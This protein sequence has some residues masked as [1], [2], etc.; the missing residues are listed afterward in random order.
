MSDLV[1]P[2]GGFLFMKVGMHAQEELSDIIARKQAEI[3]AAGFAMWG[4]GGNTCHP[5]TMVQPFAD[6]CVSAGD[7]ILLCMQPMVSNHVAEPIRA[8][9]YS[10]DGKS[11]Q[12]IPQEIAVLGSKYA[13]CIREL[14]QVDA[15]ISLAS[16]RVALGRSKGR[17]GDQYVKG[18]VDKAC[19]TMVGDDGHAGASPTRI[20]L[21]A[22]IVE[23]YAVFLRY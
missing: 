22:Q 14:E 23:P 10:V 16:T 17:A 5:R 15:E 18:R 7:P 13:L 20:G 6:S 9:E 12:E 21:V 1:A 19:L 4:Y 8:E 3:S 2:G 11:W